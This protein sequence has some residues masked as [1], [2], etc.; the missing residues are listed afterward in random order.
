MATN[1]TLEDKPI[2][3]TLSLNSNQKVQ[4]VILIPTI[5]LRS[6][7][8]ETIQ[9]ILQQS[10]KKLR[11]KKPKRLFLVKHGMQHV[12]Q[13]FHSKN[14]N[15]DGLGGATG[16]GDGEGNGGYIKFQNG[17]IVIVSAGEDY[18]GALPMISNLETTTTTT[19]TVE[20]LFASDAAPA[21]TPHPSATTAPNLYKTV[22]ILSHHAPLDPLAIQQ[23]QSTSQSLHHLTHTIGMPD[24][25]P[26]TKHPVGAV[27]ISQNGVVYP[28]LVGGDVGCGMGLYVLE[29]GF[30]KTKRGGGS[31]GRWDVETVAEDLRKWSGRL[32]GLESGWGDM[33]PNDTCGGGG[34]GGGERMVSEYLKTRLEPLDVERDAWLEPFHQHLGTIG[35]GNHF[36]EI[37]VLDHVNDREALYTQLGLKETDV[38]LLVH[39]GSRGLGKWIY[40]SHIE[41]HGKG[42]EGVSGG[43]GGGGGVMMGTEA[44]D[45]YMDRQRKACL[46]ARYNRDLIA[47]RVVSMLFENR[48]AEMPLDNLE[49]SIGGGGGGGDQ[50]QNNGDIGIRYLRK[51][52]D[53]WHNN[54]E[55][56]KLPMPNDSSSSSSS[57]S[58]L[59]N[60]SNNVFYIHRKG[61]APADRGIVP[62]P[63][64]RGAHT[65]LVQPSIK[66]ATTITTTTPSPDKTHENDIAV[67]LKT[68]L[69]LPHGAGRKWTRSKALQVFKTKLEKSER[70]QRQQ[71][72][73]NNN[74]DKYNNSSKRDFNKGGGRVSDYMM[75]NIIDDS[76][77]DI[78]D[79]HSND[80]RAMPTD[81]NSAT[82]L[83][84]MK[85]NQK[86][87]ANVHNRPSQQPFTVSS[88]TTT[89]LSSLVIC[90]D[91]DLLFEEAPEAYKEI[92]S[93]I[94]DVVE[95][96]GMGRVVGVLRPVV[97]YKMRKG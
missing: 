5:V 55:A 43:G 10:I 18:I 37:Q 59:S 89:S 9:Y 21:P 33:E 90:E 81:P 72:S 50:E 87:A 19:T 60:K 54:V 6:P 28:E 78:P 56:L 75:D 71:N 76:R 93:V 24:L 41:R 34:G 20:T 32:R 53:I 96:F 44:G 36:A 39:S 26:G 27:Y 51:V 65:Y 2:R 23:L 79:S 91:R 64:S 45:E 85:S 7:F 1:T 31:N 22:N 11:I 74:S 84:N 48:D 42:G 69:S 15:L 46:W 57:S 82:S 61:A 12:Q 88:L 25:C 16:D 8:T 14:E 77:F 86:A 3:L 52:I 47:H 80:K 4:S 29:G 68:G 58:E 73:S 62:I 66:N 49:I 67:L 17:D 40:D 30:M 13:V 92:E 97:T 94:K 38:L 83:H 63:G 35:G 70:R 95:E